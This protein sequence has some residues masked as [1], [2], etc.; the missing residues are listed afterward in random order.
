LVLNELIL[1]AVKHSDPCGS[2][3]TVS[4]GSDGQTAH[5]LIRNTLNGI[6]D[7]DFDTGKGFGTGLRLL[8]SLLP[9]EGVDLRYEQDS[10]GFMLT[11][12]KLTSPV[13]LVSRQ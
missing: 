4:L 3:P 5:I 11:R 9:N 7:F 13:I 8:R 10:E 2:P 6:P 12:V 1:N